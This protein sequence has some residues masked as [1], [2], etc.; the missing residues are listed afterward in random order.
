MLL[1]V[2]WMLLYV[3]PLG[4]STFPASGGWLHPCS[5][6]FCL[7]WPLLGASGSSERLA[8]CSAPS[9]SLCCCSHISL[10][11]WGWKFG[12]LPHPC[13]LGQIQHSTP[14]STVG[15]KITVCCLCFSFLFVGGSGAVLD[16]FL[17]EWVGKSHMVSDAYLFIVHIHS[18][19]FGTS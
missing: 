12:F 4:S 16:Y 19:S 5:Q 8:C 13:S 9:L 18:R 2:S 7:S 15:V 3:P 11:V 1:S 10:R 17:R 6:P 14:T